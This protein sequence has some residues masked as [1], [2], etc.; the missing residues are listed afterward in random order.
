ML[1]KMAQLT[2]ISE[3]IIAAVDSPIGPAVGC[4]LEC[5]YDESDG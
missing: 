2:A 4:P 1:G 5:D 3:A